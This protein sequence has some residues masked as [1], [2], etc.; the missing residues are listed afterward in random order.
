MTVTEISSHSHLQNTDSSNERQ[1]SG[2][3]VRDAFTDLAQAL[4]S[5]NLQGA[6]QAFETIQSARNAHISNA[7]TATIGN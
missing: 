1:I 2:S 5:G 3:S 7:Q 6:Q 4:Q